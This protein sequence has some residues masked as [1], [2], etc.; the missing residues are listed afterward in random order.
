MS[1]VVGS[2]DRRT[3]RTN[4]KLNA[5]LQEIAITGKLLSHMEKKTFD[6]A[7]NAIDYLAVRPWNYS[8]YTPETPSKEQVEVAKAG[9][10]K[11]AESGFPEP[12]KILLLNDGTFGAHWWNT[13][14]VYISVDFDADEKIIIWT[15]ISEGVNKVGSFPLSDVIPSDLHAVLL[16]T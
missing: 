4:L 6:Y 15:I 8:D 16:S 12:S 10:R 2:I 5:V 7:F 13:N 3:L 1:R 11:F 14:G 9:L